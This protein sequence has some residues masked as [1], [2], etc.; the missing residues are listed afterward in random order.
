[1]SRVGKKA[2]TLEKGVA[3]EVKDSSVTVKGPKGSLT[4]Q[5]Q[6]G[7][8]TQV[9]DGVVQVVRSSDHRTLRGLHGLTRA[10][11]QNMIVG[12][13]KGY[14]KK[15]EMTGVGYKAEKKE[16]ELLLYVGFPK[17][18]SVPI[19]K[20]IAVTIDGKGTIIILNGIDKEQ[21]GEI[22]ADI[23][24]IRPPEPYKGKGIRYS[25][26]RILRKVGKTGS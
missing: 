18:K 19:P 1:M 5:L 3:V 12:V 20:E 9:K 11:I 15:L 6:P 14:E 16:G 23:R 26:E 17:P 25:T 21:L 8:E 2:I 22:A 10:L 13:S 24:R 7:I 4:Y